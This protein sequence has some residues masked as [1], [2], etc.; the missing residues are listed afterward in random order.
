MVHHAEPA[1]RAVNGFP[2]SEVLTNH[3]M[4]TLEGCRAITLRM[5]YL[6]AFDTF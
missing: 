5:A 2:A 6:G 1:D 4:I 3:T